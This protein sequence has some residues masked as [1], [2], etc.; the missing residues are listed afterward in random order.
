MIYGRHGYA[1]NLKTSVWVTY[2]WL[3]RSRKQEVEGHREVGEVGEEEVVLHVVNVVLER[4]MEHCPIL[5][6]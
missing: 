1:S 4:V 2:L 5:C 6:K 3:R